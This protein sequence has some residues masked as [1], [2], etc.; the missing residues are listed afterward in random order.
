VLVYGDL[1]LGQANEMKRL[2]EEFGVLKVDVVNCTDCQLGRKGKSIEADPDYNLMF[3]GP[4]MIEFFTHMKENMLK[5]SVDEAMFASMFNGIKGIVFL[6]TCCHPEKG[7]KE[8]KKL[9]MGLEVI[10]I[11]K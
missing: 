10:E 6:D 9:G 2:A 4:G 7:L 11:R 1:C 8:L 3:T 5:E